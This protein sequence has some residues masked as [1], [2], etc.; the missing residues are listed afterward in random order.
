M[1]NL[2]TSI[3]AVSIVLN[4]YYIGL[5][6]YVFNSYDNHALR[7]Q[8]FMDF[9]PIKISMSYLNLFLILVTLVSLFVIFRQIKKNKNFEQVA[10]LLQLIFIAFQIWQYL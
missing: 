9:Y 7:V 10:I 8:K 6:I 5:W 2:Y 3:I 1:R 4:T